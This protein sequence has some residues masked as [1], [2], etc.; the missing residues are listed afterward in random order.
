M[1]EVE[2]RFER[3]DQEGIVAVGTYVIDAARRFG[4]RF[5]EL[6]DLEKNEHSCSVFVK[7]GAD[8][9][10]PETRAESEHFAGNG[11]RTNERL[12][13]Q[14]KIDKPG[15]VVIMTQEKAQSPTQEGAP[16]EDRNE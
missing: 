3:E 14:V 8:R 7:T 9:L 10:S 4:I 12:A 6:C 2:I 11:R 1:A 13:C 16:A 5:D 15:E